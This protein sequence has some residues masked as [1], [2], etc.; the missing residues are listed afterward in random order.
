MRNPFS[1]R[2]GSVLTTMSWT[3]VVGAYRPAACTIWFTAAWLSV[4]VTTMLDGAAFVLLPTDVVTVRLTA[5][6]PSVV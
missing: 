2:G 5:N 6:V 4:V 1:T 3:G